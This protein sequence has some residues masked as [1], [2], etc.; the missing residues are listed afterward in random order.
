MSPKDSK[1]LCKG[2]EVELYAGKETGEV[3]PTSK[4]LKENFPELSQEPDQRNFEYITIPTKSYDELLK[5]LIFPRIK[6]RK[7]LKNELGLTLIPCSTISLPFDKNFCHSKKE[8]LYHQYIAN[9]Y[10]TNVVTTS[11]HMNFGVENTSDL[12]KLLS[13]IRLDA[14]LFLALS[15]A[16]PFF[17][18]KVTGYNSFRWHNFPKTPKFVP[19]FNSHDDFITWTSEKLKNKEMYNV[20]HLW[21]TLR[22]NGPDRPHKLN[23]L[24]IRICD[25]ICDVNVILA[26]VALI[27]AKQ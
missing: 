24:E 23:R 4:I 12:F 2:I 16:S 1:L 25:L 17:D 10:K 18:G 3:V 22:P 8:D 20:R 14:P 9:T 26:I 27:E 5:E 19:F 11:L 21:T 6:I 15:A 7:F 13:A